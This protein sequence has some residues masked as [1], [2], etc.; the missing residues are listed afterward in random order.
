MLK[1]L[2]SDCIE[3]FVTQYEERQVERLTPE[4]RPKFLD[5]RNMLRTQKNEAVEHFIQWYQ[6]E[7]PT[8]GVNRLKSGRWPRN[9]WIK[10]RDEHNA[11]SRSL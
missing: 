5:R 10:F 6:K 2:P 1:L 4:K 11:I 3:T 7:Y 9:M 8:V